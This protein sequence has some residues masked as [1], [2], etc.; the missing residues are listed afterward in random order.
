MIKPVAIDHT[1]LLAKDIEEMK[2]YLERI[3]NFECFYRDESKRTLVVE[4]DLVHFF[5][6][7]FDGEVELLER[8]HISFQVNSISEVETALIRMGVRGFETGE[9]SFFKARNYK[10]CEWRDSNKIR[11]ECVE[12]RSGGV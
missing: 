7:K 12:T 3:F 2:H 10:W 9:V 11:F 1:C 8:Q 5:V 4:S 6:E